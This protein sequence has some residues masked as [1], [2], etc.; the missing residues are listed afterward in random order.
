MEKINREQLRKELIKE[1]ARRSYIDYVDYVNQGKWVKGK[2]LELICEE[3]EKVLNNETN[4]LILSIPPQHGK[5]MLITETLPS[6]YLGKFPEKRVIVASYG[7]DLAM[8]FGRRNKQKIQEF[9]KELFNIELSK[10]SSSD[11]EFEIETHKGSMISRGIMSGITGQPADL[12]IVDD[13][14]KNRLEANS[15]TFRARLKEE[16]LNSLNTRLSANGK[17]II[18]QTR[19]HEDDLAGWLIDTEPNKWKVINIPC[20]AEENDILGRQV[21]DAL[22]PEIGK[23]NE[24]LQEFKKSYMTAEGSMAWNALFQGRPTSQEGNMI[25]RSWFNYIEQQ[26]ITNYKLISVDATFKDG[27]NSDYVSIQVWGKHGVKY[28]FIDRIKAKMDFVDTLVA[29][30]N[31]QNKHKA[32]LILIEDKANGSAIISMLKKEFNNILAV[33]PEGGKVARVNAV[34]PIM[35]AG[36]VYLLKA[37]WN[38]DFVEECASFPNGKHDDD[39]DA[40]SQ[41]LTRLKDMPADDIVLSEEEQYRQRQYRQ[42]VSAIAGN[43]Y[44]ELLN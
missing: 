9:G 29:I 41:A 10:S 38:N 2:H 35:E 34:A 40:M 15:E 4:R 12:I 31:M 14:I 44:S 24:W 7:E 16:W 43:D 21:G 28:Y 17:V 1:L 3:I 26:P 13:P 19:W 25:K 30:R 42:Q 18:I 20:E 37:G 36:N 11:K 32:N 6:Y 22:F 8:K 33:N 23:D 39:V 27:D 5:S